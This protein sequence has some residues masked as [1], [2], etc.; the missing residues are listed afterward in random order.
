[1]LRILIYGKAETDAACAG[2]IKITYLFV[3]YFKTINE[4]AVLIDDNHF[5]QSVLIPVREPPVRR[6][7]AWNVSEVSR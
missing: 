6:E 1:M 5:E 4:R 7:N 3:R 2:E